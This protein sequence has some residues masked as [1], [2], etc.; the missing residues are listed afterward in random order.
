MKTEQETER[1]DVDA[2]KGSG[3]SGLLLSFTMPG[4]PNSY[5]SARIEVWTE[6]PHGPTADD[7]RKT[8]QR[9][10]EIVSDKMED[11]AATVQ[12]YFSGK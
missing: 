3:S 4:P 12:E 9:C 11:L 6:L 7:A 5:M 1:V 8:H 10:E 2:T